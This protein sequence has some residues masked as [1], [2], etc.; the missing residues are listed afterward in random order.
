M[1]S[2][3]KR[4]LGIHAP[5]SPEIAAYGRLKAKG[6]TPDRI[7]DVGAYEGDW[8]RLVRGVFDKSPVTMIEAQEGKKAAL[9]AVCRELPGV[10]L[11]SA[12]L[13]PTSGSQVPFYEMETGSS[14]RAENSNVARE[15]KLM[16][17]QTLDEAAGQDGE[18]LFIKIDVQGAELDVLSGGLNILE[19][20]EVVQLETA[21]LPYNDGAPQIA[22]VFVQ[23]EKWGF[24]PYDFAGFIRP[25]GTDLV[26]TDVIF[27]RTASAL[28]PSHF[29]F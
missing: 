23:M 1:R 15:E 21:L 20:C 7:I 10:T 18:R 25:N 5:P 11:V 29:T 24:S 12:L 26:Q 8:T 22:E 6:F 19:R 13:A 14:M 9:E 2:L 17:T 27:V 4:V 3:L 28:R 16:T